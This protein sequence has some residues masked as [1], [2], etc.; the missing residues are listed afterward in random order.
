MFLGNNSII[1]KWY[2]GH[3]P[4]AVAALIGAVLLFILPTNWKTKEFTFNWKEAACIDWGTIIL[5]GGGLSLGALM[6]STGL[7]NALGQW[8]FSITGAKSLWAITATA[9]ALGI[10]ISEFTSN[11][12]SANTV[13]PIMISLSLAAGVNPLP[14]A[15]GACLGA[16]YGF[17]LPVSTPPNAI[18]YGSGMVPITKM[19][20][21]GIIFDIVGFFIILFGMF[22]FLP[23]AGI[24]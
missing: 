18:V 19:I 4:E 15:I 2:E 10:V 16:S 17:M 6:F 22:I 5:F 1:A 14:P 12:A 20:R 3:I 24:K 9:I 13:I 11:T 8:L 7:A 23:L 21:A